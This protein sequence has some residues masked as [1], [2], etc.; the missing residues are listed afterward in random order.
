MKY[1]L[2]NKRVRLSSIDGMGEFP[3]EYILGV[4]T[5]C[6]N[7]CKCRIKLEKALDYQGQTFKELNVYTRHEGY[8][9][10]K[11]F[12]RGI[13]KLFNITNIVAVNVF[14][15]DDKIRFVAEIELD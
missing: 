11:I 10:E 9:L 2:R 3:P 1:D 5:E 13:K 15:D 8:S 12:K 6:N 7:P 14:D 4:V